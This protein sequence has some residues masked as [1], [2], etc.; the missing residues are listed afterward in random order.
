[1]I[2]MT[3]KF[4]L[5]VMAFLVTSCFISCDEE[6]KEDRII[7]RGTL[8]DNSGRI[9]KTVRIGNKWWMAENLAVRK[10]NNG[11]EIPFVSSQ[12]PD[13]SWAN[14]GGP[15][16]TFTL[17]ST[18]GFLYNYDCL[19]DSRGI[20]PDGWRIPTDEDWKDLE[21]EIGMSSSEINNT[22]W[23]GVSEA[24]LLTSK[25]SLGWAQGLLFGTDEF[26]FDARS[27][28]VRIFDGRR[29]LSGKVAFWWTLTEN[30]GDAWY[31]YMDSDQ[32][33]IFRHYTDKNYAMAIR[34]V[35]DI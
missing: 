19:T 12:D 18:V 25:N 30:E 11:D 7:E 2:Q 8:T 13:I 1:M 5:M 29:N 26:G 15:G 17:D 22:S 32:T 34:L 24:P 20:A 14:I 31:R 4:F 35:K 33:R 10:F 16:V 9:Y 28:G 3:R 27:S 21:K 23:R 6:E